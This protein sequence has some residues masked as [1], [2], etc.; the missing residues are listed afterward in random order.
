MK[1]TLPL[2]IASLLF[3]AT[4]GQKNKIYATV[5][6]EDKNPIARGLFMSAADSGIIILVDD[7]EVFVAATEIT[8]LKIEKNSSKAEFLKLGAAV[9]SDAAAGYLINKPQEESPNMSTDSSSDNSVELL[10]ETKEILFG[11][12]QKLLDNLQSGVNDLATVSI[13]NSQDK[14]LTKLRLLQQ[15]SIDKE[16]ISMSD[17]VQNQQ[18]QNEIIPEQTNE[19]KVVTE[20]KKDDKQNQTVSNPVKPAPPKPGTI[21]LNKGFYIVKPPVNTTSNTTVNTGQKPQTI[22]KPKTVIITSPTKAPVE[23]K[24]VQPKNSTPVLVPVKK[25]TPTTIK[26]N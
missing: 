2:I 8:V 14:F 23:T 12:I 11:R 22:P 21:T 4:F 3:T 15:Y 6:D 9:A 19:E 5:F 7:L 20:E 25:E 16:I 18:S 1:K 24:P 10:T 13:N 26:K 17:F